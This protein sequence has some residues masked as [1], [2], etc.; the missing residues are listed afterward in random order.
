MGACRTP[1]ILY[2]FTCRPWWHFIKTEG[3]T[4]GEVPLSFRDVLQHPNLTSNPDPS[5]QRWGCNSGLNKTAVRITVE[6]PTGDINLI[7]WRDLATRHK[8]DRRW[9]RALDEGG[10]WEARNWWIYQGV[11]RPEW[12][13]DVEFFDGG[14]L[15]ER[16]ARILSICEQSASYEDV[17]RRI[18]VEA[19]NGFVVYDPDLAAVG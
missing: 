14:K 10:G 2:H 9:Y 1:G 19:G 11:V 17:V 6:I 7:S 16:E 8:V 12:F 4:R 15:G 18:G 3:I 5:A 13:T